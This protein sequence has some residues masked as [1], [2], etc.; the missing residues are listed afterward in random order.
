[1]LSNACKYAIRA[2]I[3]LANQS[4]NDVRISIKAL[5]KAVDSPE[6]FTAKIMQSLSRKGLVSSVKGPNGGFYLTNKQASISLIDIVETIDG[7]AAL[8]GCG[9]GLT[10]C[11]DGHPCPIHFA[12][13]EVRESFRKILENNTIISLAKELN[14]GN[15][16]L[17]NQL[18]S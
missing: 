10:S 2:M 4:G 17:S 9:L 7:T 16:V 15:T 6:P 5:S 18:L 8:D 1:M 13:R 3:F 14:A 11:S 12:Y